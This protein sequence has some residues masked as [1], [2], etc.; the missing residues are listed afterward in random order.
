[1]YAK[2][3]SKKVHEKGIND[4]SVSDNLVLSVSDDQFLTGSRES[5]LE[6]VFTVKLG[7]TRTLTPL[8]AVAQAPNSSLA[9]VGS[10]DEN[11]YI[12][13]VQ[14]E[15]QVLCTLP[16][17]ADPVTSVAWSKNTGNHLATCSYDALTR[18]WDGRT[19]KCI[20]TLIGDTNPPVISVQF[21]DSGDLVTATL[22]SKIT[23]WDWRVGGGRPL[24]VFD[25]HENK[26][27]IIRPCLHQD[28]LIMGSEDGC[29]YKYSISSDT[30]TCVK[31]SSQPII[32]I[33]LLTGA[34][35]AWNQLESNK[36]ELIQNDF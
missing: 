12:V 11:V 18:I 25:K 27:Y 16:A 3:L 10:F 21:L 15:G 7:S 8:T 14:R 9:A 30:H 29:V 32:N 4:V 23:Q 28:H 6:Q 17:H 19:S 34:T 31:L 24:K 2:G 22:D 1:M 26:K 35:I 5:D 20:A 33:A 36:I 13:D